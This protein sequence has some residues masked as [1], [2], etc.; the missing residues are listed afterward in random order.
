M[1]EVGL[2][3]RAGLLLV[4]WFWTST[5]FCAVK[6]SGTETLKEGNFPVREIW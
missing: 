6:D 4:I 1:L 5:N 2:W 3:M